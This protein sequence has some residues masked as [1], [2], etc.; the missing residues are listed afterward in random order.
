MK[1]NDMKDILT[2]GKVAQ[3]CGCSPRSVAKWFDS[4]LLAGYRIPPGNDR[5]FHLED[6]RKFAESHGIPLREDSPQPEPE[7]TAE[8]EGEYFTFVSPTGVVGGIFYTQEAAQ[9][10]AIKAGFTASHVKRLVAYSV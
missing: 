6:V 9:D 10:A 2:T 7:P 5:R 1:A 4:G 8:K 3:L